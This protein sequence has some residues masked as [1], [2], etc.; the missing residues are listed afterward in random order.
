MTAPARPAGPGRHLALGLRHNAA[1]FTLLVV[2]NA[3]RLLAYQGA[4]V[5]PAHS[6]AAPSTAAEQ[7]AG[8]V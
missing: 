8:A 5:P 1:Q 6:A 7:P 4:A 3:L 2:V